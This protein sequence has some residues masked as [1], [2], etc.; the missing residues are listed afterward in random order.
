MC[1]LISIYIYISAWA[2]C[3]PILFTFK[4]SISVT[5]WALVRILVLSSQRALV[6]CD[7]LTCN[8]IVYFH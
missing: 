6:S 1:A 3:L 4:I 5:M 2:T 7:L 8:P